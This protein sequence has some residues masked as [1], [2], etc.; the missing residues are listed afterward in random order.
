MRSA[1][2][3]ALPNLVVP[4]ERHE[5]PGHEEVPEQRQ[6]DAGPFEDHRGRQCQGKPRH[7]NLFQPIGHEQYCRDRIHD[8]QEEEVEDVDQPEKNPSVWHVPDDVPR[9]QPFHD[10][11]KRQKGKDDAPEYALTEQMH[12]RSPPGDRRIGGSA[13]AL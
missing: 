8:Q 5:G 11:E 13:G 1:G 7:V 9:R 6:D 12:L 2:R 3:G 10:D 4:A